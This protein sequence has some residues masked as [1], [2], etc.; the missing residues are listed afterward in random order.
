MMQCLPLLPTFQGSDQVPAA[1]GMNPTNPTS[2]MDN[3]QIVPGAKC[4][5]FASDHKVSRVSVCC[6][7]CVCAHVSLVFQY[8]PATVLSPLN[9]TNNSV[10]ISFDATGFQ[11]NVHI[12]TLKFT[13]G[14]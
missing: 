9:P 11:A 1:P 8:Y 7:L 3:R 10:M 12:N 6:L 4:E 14:S 5:V 2:S 13:T